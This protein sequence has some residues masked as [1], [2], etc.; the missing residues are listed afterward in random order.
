MRGRRL[1]CLGAACL[2]LVG[3]ALQACG[4]DDKGSSGGGGAPTT[5]TVQVLPISDVVPTYL[6]VDKGFFKEQKLKIKTQTAQGGAEIIP[7]VMNGSVQIGYSNTPSL[8]I[9]AGKG[10]PIQLVAPADGGIGKKKGKKAIDA[11]MVK[12]NSPIRKPAD[13]VGKTI[14][15]NTLKN[16][17]DV[18]TSGALD[19]LGVDPRGVKYLEVPLPDMQGALDAGRVDAVFTVSPFKTLMEGSGNYRTIMNSEVVLRPGMHNT[20]YFVS[21]QW[22]DK[23]PDVLERFLKALKKSMQYSATH[24]AENREELGKYTELPKA[25]IPT[26]PI[27]E[28]I[29]DCTEFVASSKLLI[30]VMV[31]FGA[32]EKSPN[33]DELIRPGFCDK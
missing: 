33:L 7:Q 29:P 16:I 3:V 9:A 18:S 4:G 8:F 11:I 20:A 14:A 25:I 23:N 24:D 26:I 30:E 6:G 31:K 1:R 19:K 28:R 15:V 21:K 5:L 27:G 32:L 22:A 10:L 17:S 13:L 2:I 12:K